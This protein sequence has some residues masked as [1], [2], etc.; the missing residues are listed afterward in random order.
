MMLLLVYRPVVK[1]VTAT[2]TFTG[3][4]YLLPVMC[5]RP[6]SASTMTS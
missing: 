6:N 1:S 3:G 2:P 5:M 4:P